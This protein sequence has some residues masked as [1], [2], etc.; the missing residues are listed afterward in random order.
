MPKKNIFKTCLLSLEKKFTNNY[1]LICLIIGTGV[2]FGADEGPEYPGL[3]L[4]GAGL[5]A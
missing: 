1:L 5:G 3:I 2:G 4:G